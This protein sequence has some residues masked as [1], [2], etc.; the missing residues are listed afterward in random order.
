[1]DEVLKTL[2]LSHNDTKVIIDVCK[3][4]SL[5]DIY[6]IVPDG[7][8]GKL[9]EYILYENCFSEMLALVVYTGAGGSREAFTTSP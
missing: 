7:F 8:E 9:S 2:G 4:L 6:W 5:N 1:M 3:G